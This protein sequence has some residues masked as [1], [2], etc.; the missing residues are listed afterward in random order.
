MAILPLTADTAWLIL[1][2]VTITLSIGGAAWRWSNRRISNGSLFAATLLVASCAA[3]SVAA[4]RSAAAESLVLVRRDVALRTEP[5]LAGEAGARARGGE[6]AVVQEVRG[7]WRLL[8]IPGGR[9]GWVESENVQSLA[10][11]DGHDVALAE[12]RIA[13]EG[14]AP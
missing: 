4:Q 10:M 2:G 5:V 1:L 13:S 9:A 6:I 3:L 12:V 14:P 11:S 7:T 8:A